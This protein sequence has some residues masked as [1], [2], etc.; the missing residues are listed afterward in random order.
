M[1]SLTPKRIKQF[2]DDYII[3]QEEAKKIISVAVYNHYK[4]ISIKERDPEI[5][6]EKSNIIM[7][8]PSGCG[9][10][11]VVKALSKILNVPFAIADA[12]TLTAAG[13]VGSDVE[14]VLQ[15]LLSSADNNVEEAQKV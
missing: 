14:V 5:E 13:Y 1:S 6:L 9:K 15:R 2:L 12:S 3:G 7:L 4:S 11:A 10:T 8:G